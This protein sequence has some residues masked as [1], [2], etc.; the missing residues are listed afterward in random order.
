M[1]L[2]RTLPKLRRSSNT[3][4]V[5][6]LKKM[7][8]RHREIL[9]RVV[10]ACG[11]W[12]LYFTVPASRAGHHARQKGLLLHTLEVA[13][14][15]WAIAESIEL[16][17]VDRDLLLLLAMLHDVGKLHEYRDTP[18]G[19]SM[20]NTGRWV[21]HQAMACL[22]L[23]QAADA[24]AGQDKRLVLA[25]LNGIAGSESPSAGQSRGF[26]TLEA[27]IVHRADQIS[28]AADLFSLSMR[29]TGRG[30]FYGT[31]HPH[32]REQPLHPVAIR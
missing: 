18:Y 2:G 30:K 26:A 6:I 19:V 8:T 27:T 9:G 1:P 10:E 15:S 20:S 4:F 23:G 12:D 31:R 3:R 5:E 22:G 16:D 28:A 25:L 29:T 32:L 14:L 24:L 21:G 7:S 17:L 13:E 11:G